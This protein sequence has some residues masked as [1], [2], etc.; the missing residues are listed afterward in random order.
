LAAI[1]YFATNLL[2][3]LHGDINPDQREQ[4]T[5]TVGNVRQLTDM[6]SDLLDITRVETHKIVLEPQRADTARLIAEALS[7][8]CT[9]AATKNIDLRSKPSAGLPFA[10]ADPVRV[11]QILI[12]LIDNGIK[13]TP[14]NGI[15]TV[16]TRLFAENSDF[17]CLSVTDTGCGISAENR[18]LVFRRLAQVKNNVETSRAGLGLGL[19]ISSELV[20]MHGGQI[21]LDSQV[22]HGTTFFFTIPVF[23]LTRLCAHFLRMEHLE[24]GSVTLIAMDVVAVGG[25]LDENVISEMRRIVERCIRNG[26]DVCLP[27]MTDPE[28]RGM[29]TFFVLACVDARAAEA[30]ANR[31]GNEL[32]NFDEASKLKQ[33]LFS[34]TLLVAPGESNEQQIGG[35][36]IWIERLV[37]AHL[38]DKET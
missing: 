31:I 1:Y 15:V 25:V 16:E 8:C 36:A 28:Q 24:T 37:K 4:L 32:Q 26:R 2:D 33:T 38:A 6:V 7:T 5:R 23:S 11:R 19:F 30:I 9:N 3:G 12:N 14:D 20:L 27:S 17:L 22:G 13:F 29:E 35:V 21:W 10:W 18:D 34:T